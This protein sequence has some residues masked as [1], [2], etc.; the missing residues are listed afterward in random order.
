M[1]TYQCGQLVSHRCPLYRAPARSGV[2]E[3]HFEPISLADR[4]ET[5][6]LRVLGL[7]ALMEGKPAVGLFIQGLDDPPNR[8]QDNDP[9]D[10][11]TKQHHA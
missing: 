8:C 4:L 11:R 3:R 7:K 6:V 10:D 5:R 9:V 1:G 2:S